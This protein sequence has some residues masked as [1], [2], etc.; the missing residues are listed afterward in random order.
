MST[1]VPAEEMVHGPN[2]SNGRAK[3]W[4]PQGCGFRRLWRRRPVSSRR[5]Q[6]LGPEKSTGSPEVRAWTC[7]SGSRHVGYFGRRSAAR[8]DWDLLIRA[9]QP[10]GQLPAGYQH[11]RRDLRKSTD[12]RII[13]YAAGRR[14]QHQ[15]SVCPR[16]C[17]RNLVNGEDSGG[18]GILALGSG[19]S[20]LAG[21]IWETGRTS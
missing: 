7:C 8:V 12:D 18:E 20:P 21:L 5:T 17:A 10:G 16:N 19:R 14:G 6:R 2:H 1:A 13:G 15:S 9:Q 4:Q 11:R 3:S